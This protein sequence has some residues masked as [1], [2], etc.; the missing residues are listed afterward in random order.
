MC[1]DERCVLCV[2]NRG[3]IQKMYHILSKTLAW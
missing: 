3:E 1:V 2:A